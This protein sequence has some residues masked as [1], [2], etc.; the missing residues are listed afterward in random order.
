MHGK[1]Y[2][3]KL[4]TLYFDGLKQYSN[5]K[6]NFTDFWV[7]NDTDIDV[8][9]VTIREHLANFGMLTL[10]VHTQGYKWQ[11]WSSPHGKALI[12]ATSL[13]KWD[14]G[15]VWKGLGWK[16]YLFSLLCYTCEMY[17]SHGWA[18]SFLNDLPYY[19]FHVIMVSTDMWVQ[20]ASAI[21]DGGITMAICTVVVF[22]QL[23]CSLVNR[24]REDTKK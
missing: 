15:H 5:S 18:F 23:E 21:G 20:W 2:K 7:R 6:H 10:D 9:H 13:L 16:F 14:N 4:A 12:L 3:F 24:V 17:A 19:I 11:F 1:Q 22:M 8:H